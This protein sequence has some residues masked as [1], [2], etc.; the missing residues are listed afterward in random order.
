MSEVFPPY[1]HIPALYSQADILSKIWN[2]NDG[3]HFF[4]HSITRSSQTW[5][6]QL[7]KHF[8]TSFFLWTISPNIFEKVLCFLLSEL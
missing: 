3:N 1:P 2:D 5:V 4:S 8:S 7:V 6:I